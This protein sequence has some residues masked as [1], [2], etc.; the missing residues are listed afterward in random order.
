V[1]RVLGD[2]VLGVAGPA[3]PDDACLLVLDW[4][5]GHGNGRSTAAGADPTITSTTPPG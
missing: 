1:V 4:R 3:L 5:G 2:T